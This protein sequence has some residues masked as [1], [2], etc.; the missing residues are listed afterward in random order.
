VRRQTNH[1]KGIPHPMFDTELPE[2]VF[3]GERGKVGEMA[4]WSD[5]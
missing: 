1:P 3:V 5:E 4:T 2:T